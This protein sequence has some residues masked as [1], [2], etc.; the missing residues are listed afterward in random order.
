MTRRHPATESADP[1]IAELVP[2]MP[3]FVPVRNRA[4]GIQEIPSRWLGHPT[5][6]EGF[7]L[8]P[9]FRAAIEKRACEATQAAASTGE[10]APEGDAVDLDTEQDDPA[11]KEA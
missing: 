5:L 2:H 1:D 6:G 8:T 10:T 3:E 4:G 9:R 11:T 7:T